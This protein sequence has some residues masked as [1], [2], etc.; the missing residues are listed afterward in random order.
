MERRLQVKMTG[1]RAFFV[2]SK[3]RSLSWEARR[4]PTEEVEFIFGEEWTSASELGSEPTN[5]DAANRQSVGIGRLWSESELG[6]FL[7][8]DEREERKE[9]D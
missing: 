9:R 3:S 4:S 6:F 1:Y 5:P 8:S 2:L 7:E